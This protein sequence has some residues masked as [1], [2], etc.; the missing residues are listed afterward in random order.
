MPEGLEAVR[1]V[2]LSGFI[3]GSRYTLQ[4]RQIQQH[5]IADTFPDRHYDQCGFDGILIGHPVGSR[6]AKQVKELV[7]QTIVSV[8]SPV[9]HDGYRSQ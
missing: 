5:R 2:K 9:P 1:S 8:V 4:R 6:Y 7:N 3:V